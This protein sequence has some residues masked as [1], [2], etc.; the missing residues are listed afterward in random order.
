MATHANNFDFIRLAA[1]FSVLVSHQFAFA[2]K[3]EP[4]PVPF[5]SLGGLAVLAFFT[6]SGFLVTQSWDRDR[7]ALRFAAR[8]ILRIWPGWIVVTIF[9]GLILGPLITTLSLPAYFGS[10]RTWEY[11]GQLVLMTKYTLP[12]VFTTNSVPEVVNGSLW[13]LP[14][15]VQ[16]Y[17]FLLVAGVTSL[18]KWRWPALASLV[19]FAFYLFVLKDV[20]HHH[21][22]TKEFGLFFLAGSCCYLF[23]DCW[24][25]R[26]FHFLAPL[27]VAAIILWLCGYKYAALFAIGPLGLLAFGLAKWPAISRT[28]RYGDLSYGVYIYAGPVQQTIIWASDNSFSVF[29]GG[30]LATGMTLVLAFLSWHLI[31]KPSMDFGRTRATRH[32]QAATQNIG[33]TAPFRS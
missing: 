25:G 31:E 5:H 27:L 13:T 12:G 17:A 8:R 18:L 19:I 4:S 15:E 16:M 6:I 28:G 29:A 30:A 7:H 23:R 32:K 1:A 21:K 3:P 20:E 26:I 10:T 11:L 2:G 9:T 33:A 22:F 24:Q 14:I